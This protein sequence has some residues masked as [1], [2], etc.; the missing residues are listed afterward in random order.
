MAP[1]VAQRTYVIFRSCLTLLVSRRLSTSR[2][3]TEDVV[4]ERRGRGA[5]MLGRTRG[6]VGIPEAAPKDR[7]W[8]WA[9]AFFVVTYLVT[10]LLWLPVLRSGVSVAV[11]LSGRLLPLVLLASVAPSAVAVVLAGV[12]GGGRG[13]AGL[14]AQAGR[15]RF[16]VG[17]YAVALLL[18]PLIWLAALGVASLLGGRGP[19]VRLD[20]LLP[21]AAIGE[22]LGWRGYALPRLQSRIGALPASLVI[23]ILWAAWH[24]PYFADP[25]IHPLPFWLDFGGFVVVLV[26]ESVL[27]TWI[28][29]S[30]GG[31]VLAT[32]LYHHSIHLAS[33]VPAIPGALG[34]IA[35][36]IVSVA[37]AAGALAASA[38]SLVGL[39][40]GPPVSS[41]VRFGLP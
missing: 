10:A 20:F 26:S 11:A 40:R 33:L 29:N 31:S 32:T 28:Y 5:G 35:L 1:S 37:A 21:L 9:A 18:E 23:G 27:A 7:D 14:L 30:T 25:T 13:V 2:M 17:W 41:E 8:R 6:A 16:G 39:R 22:E 36:A 38:G 4:H 15:W 19:E 3:A 24:L 12:E 34:A